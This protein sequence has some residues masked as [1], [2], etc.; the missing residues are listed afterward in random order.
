MAHSSR[1]HKIFET[2]ITIEDKNINRQQLPTELQIVRCILAHS[3]FDLS[4]IN[5]AISDVIDQIRLIYE[6][7]AIPTLD[8]RLLKIRI[9]RVYSDYEKINKISADRKNFEE[10]R[11][12]YLDE[13]N[14]LMDVIGDTSACCEEDI[15]FIEN[16][17]TSRTMVMAGK[18]LLT[19]RQ[20]Q[21][22]IERKHRAMAREINEKQEISSFFAN[23]TI[24]ESNENQND[25]NLYEEKRMHCREKKR[26]FYYYPT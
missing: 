12:K 4:T 10:K 17:K 8:I 3:K 16:M 1:R 2:A 26:L 13:A 19:Q 6:R 9:R 21:E 5:D 24:D 22:E 20:A 18:D 25:D 15:K 7:A 23:D 14:K 11:K